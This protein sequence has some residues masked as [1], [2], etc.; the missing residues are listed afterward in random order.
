M[1]GKGK[2]AAET[3]LNQKLKDM[4]VDTIGEVD[5]DRNTITPSGLI[6]FKEDGE[7]VVAKWI[8]FQK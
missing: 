8:M 5:L 6:F 4:K 7:N 2:T 1:T 3:A